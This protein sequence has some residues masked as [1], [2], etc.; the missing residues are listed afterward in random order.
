MGEPLAWLL[1]WTTHGW[2]LPGDERG[3]VEKPGR[4]RQPAAQRG[5]CEGLIAGLWDDYDEGAGSTPCESGF[6]E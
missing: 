3:S 1:A 4:F 6:G 5:E 2:W